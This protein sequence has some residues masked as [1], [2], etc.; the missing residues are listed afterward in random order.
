ML[1]AMDLQALLEDHG[2]QVVGPVPS[3]ER[4][5]K[6]I[7]AQPPEAATLD[8]NLNGE[9][10]APIAAA[11]QEISVPFIVVSGYG[12]KHMGDPIFRHV[13]LVKKPYDAAEL[14]RTLAMLSK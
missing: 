4:A 6:V 14:L 13:P 12:D 2:C 5:L 11:L 8:L 3:V 7:A 10:S 9:S 1:L